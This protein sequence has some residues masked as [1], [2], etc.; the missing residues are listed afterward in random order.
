MA[1]KGKGTPKKFH[2]RRPKQ[3]DRDLEEIAFLDATIKAGAPAP[4]SNPLALN[5]LK[6]SEKGSKEQD[7]KGNAEETSELRPYAG[8][9][10]FSEL[11][12]SERTKKGLKEAK[13][14]SMTAI[15]RAAIPH[16]L[17]GRDV[18]GAAKTGSGKT[19]AFIVPLIEKLYRLRWSPMDGVGALVISPTREL[20]LQVNSLYHIANKIKGT[21]FVAA[22]R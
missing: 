11:P 7:S 5:P 9:R 8:V 1:V 16:A 3:L 4:G 14:V 22:T 18:L 15:Q 10:A 19:L 6:Q 13:Y 12:I 20:A 17:A 2:V 21:M